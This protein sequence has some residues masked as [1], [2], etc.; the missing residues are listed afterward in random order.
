MGRPRR[1]PLPAE[2][3]SALRGYADALAARGYGFVAVVE[4]AR[5]DLIGDAGLHPLGGRGPDIEVGYTL[6]RSAWGRGYGTEAARA[7]VEHAFAAL[8]APRVVAQVEPDNLA[9]RHV[10]EK[11]GMTE[12]ATRI[13]HGRPHILYGVERADYVPAPP[14]ED[15]PARRGRLTA[16]PG[17]R[18]RCALPRERVALRLRAHLGQD[19]LEARLGLGVDVPH[20]GRDRGVDLADQ[21]VH[22][23]RDGAVGRVAL[24]P[25]AQL[26]E[27]HRLARV[28][29]EDVADAVAEAQ[30][31][32][33]LA[34]AALAG[35]ALPLGG[36]RPRSA[37]R[38]ASPHPAAST[39]SGTP[40]P[41]CGVRRCHWTVSIRWRWRSRNAP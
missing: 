22:L 8:D 9:S 6:A 39:S 7:L 27:L 11:L 38:I 28:Q 4:R 34:L 12:R 14:V 3:R 13:A 41:R 20:R 5:G 32:R 17:A 40:A 10:L 1:P 24:A 33:R 19:P 15:A 31:V 25:G 37:R 26:D 18:R 35:E 16:G 21:A 36:A 2:T 23:V 29:V 30:R